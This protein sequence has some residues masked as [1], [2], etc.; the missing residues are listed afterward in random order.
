MEPDERAGEDREG[1]VIDPL[2]GRE[3]KDG[4]KGER[5]REV[6]CIHIDELEL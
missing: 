1:R 3:G 5:E 2:E 6:R 4:G